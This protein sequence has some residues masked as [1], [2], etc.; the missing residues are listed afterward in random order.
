MDQMIKN[1][2]YSDSIYFLHSKKNFYTYPLEDFYIVH[3]HIDASFLFLLLKD[4][5][6][7]HILLFVFFFFRKIF[8]FFTSLFRKLFFDFFIIVI[9]VATFDIQ[10]KNYK[11][12]FNKF[13]A[14]FEN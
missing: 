11:K 12:Y 4:F 6:I 13:F 2:L 1:V 7:N 14:C 5:Y 10:K 3:E 9:K 8:V